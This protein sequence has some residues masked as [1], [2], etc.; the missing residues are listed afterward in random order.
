M[1]FEEHCEESIAFFG[2][3]FVQVHQWLDEFAGKICIGMKHRCFRHNEAAI[4][5]I[6]EKWGILAALAVRRHIMSDLQQEGWKV[7]DHFPV[8]KKDYKR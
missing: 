8:D 3:S 6:Q 2:E 5:M 4:T 7:G 1:K